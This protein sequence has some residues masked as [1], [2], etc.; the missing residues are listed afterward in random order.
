MKKILK[1]LRM[2]DDTLTVISNVSGKACGASV[3]V[4]LAFFVVGVICNLTLDFRKR[5]ELKEKF[6]QEENGKDDN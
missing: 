4:A 6:K 5:K 3:K 2:N 1:K